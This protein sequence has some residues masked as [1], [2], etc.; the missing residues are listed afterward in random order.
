MVLGT[1]AGY[2]INRHE[3]LPLNVLSKPCV[4]LCANTHNGHIH[5]RRRHGAQAPSTRVVIAIAMEIVIVIVPVLVIVTIIV[6]VIA[7]VIGVVIVV[8]VV[9]VLIV[10]IVRSTMLLMIVMIVVIAM[11]VKCAQSQTMEC[12]RSRCCALCVRST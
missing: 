3:V 12:K 9:L 1:G 7:I 11:V 5:A 6:T 2:E 10:V 8:I 4:S